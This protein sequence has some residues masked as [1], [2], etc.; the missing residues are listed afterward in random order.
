M[1]AC[2]FCVFQSV[3]AMAGNVYGSSSVVYD[4]ANNKVKGISRTILDYETA[5][6]Y[7]PYVCGELYKEGVS[8]VR[9]CQGACCPPPLTRSSRG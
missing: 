8:Q 1:A 4:L 6:Y 9:A 2:F 3:E 5:A 7:T